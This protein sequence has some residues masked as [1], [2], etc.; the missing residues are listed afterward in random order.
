M[1]D[2]K[3]PINTTSD[4]AFLSV[5]CESVVGQKFGGATAPPV[6]TPLDC[7]LYI[8]CMF[9]FTALIHCKLCRN[10]HHI[11]VIRLLFVSVTE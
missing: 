1:T 8:G 9:V 11:F 7:N 5:V 2:I 4:G 6:L 3:E 10:N